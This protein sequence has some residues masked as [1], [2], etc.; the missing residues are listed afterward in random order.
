M[1][2]IA[3]QEF[4]NY[5]SGLV[6][7]TVTGA[8]SATN[9]LGFYSA[10]LS[11]TD[12][13][14]FSLD[15]ILGR[16]RAINDI[17]DRSGAFAASTEGDEQLVEKT[18]SFSLKKDYVYFANNIQNIFINRDFLQSIIEGEAF[19]VDGSLKRP[20]GTNGVIK[21]D[22]RATSGK[23]FGKFFEPYGLLKIPQ[24]YDTSM[25]KKVQRNTRISAYNKSAV[26]VMIEVLYEYDSLDGV[27]SDGYRMVYTN[28]SNFS[29]GEQDDAN[30]VTF[31]SMVLSDVVYTDRF[32]THGI[33]YLAEG[34][35]VAAVDAINRFAF[36]DISDATDL[37]ITVTTGEFTVTGSTLPTP[38][39]ATA[40]TNWCTAYYNPTGNAGVYFLL[41]NI[42]GT[43]W[44][45][46]SNTLNTS[47]WDIPA[48]TAAAADAATTV[49]AAG[50]P[51]YNYDFITA[52]FQAI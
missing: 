42:D 51:C 44:K 47:T 22:K 10:A 9:K 29:M 4:I 18:V 28:N 16:A 50:V 23:T 8:D 32:F 52:A 12:A 25:N 34:E 49:T 31:D 3:N 27:K 45:V 7:I 30:Q 41:S 1:Q 17:F 37:T 38:L 33:Q 21:F 35:N 5:R 46:Y 6:K 2:A 36:A 14:T 48:V 40:N 20:L 39:S 19:S 26:C 24:A 11:T 13:L 15:T 43:D